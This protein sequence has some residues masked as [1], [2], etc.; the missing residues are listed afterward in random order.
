[1]NVRITED[2]PMLMV[3]PNVSA[4]RGTKEINVKKVINF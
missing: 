4:L 3:H 2:A 1:M